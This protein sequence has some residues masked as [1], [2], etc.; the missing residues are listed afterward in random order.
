VHVTGEDKSFIN[1]ILT[2]LAKAGL[3]VSPDAVP[4]STGMSLGN[5]GSIVAATIF[6]GIKPIPQ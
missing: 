6:V 5:D 1:A 4:P 2:A 3:A